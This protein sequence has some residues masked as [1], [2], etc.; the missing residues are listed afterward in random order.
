MNEKLLKGN[1]AYDNGFKEPQEV[2]RL[3]MDHMVELRP[4][5]DVTLKAYF[6][7]PMF[8]QKSVSGAVKLE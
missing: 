8:M 2:M 3:L 5:K 7:Q 6:K 1:S 4:R